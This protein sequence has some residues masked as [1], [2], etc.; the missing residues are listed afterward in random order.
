VTLRNA[1]P[2]NGTATIWTDLL[3]LKIRIFFRKGLDGKFD[4][5]T[6]LPVGSSTPDQTFVPASIVADM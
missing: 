4:G 3:F 6:D 2:R 1:P 5:R